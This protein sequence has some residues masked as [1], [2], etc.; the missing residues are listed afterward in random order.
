MATPERRLVLTCEHGGHA[1]PAVW[2]ALFA[3]RREWLASH[4]GW[5]SGALSVARM[6]ARATGSPLIS[7]TTTRLLVDLNRSSHNPAVFSEVTRPLS[8]RQREQLLALHHR[9]H[10]DR[11]RATLAA[12]RRPAIHVAVH[13]FTPIWHG[14]PRSVGIGL[15]YDPR[16]PAERAFAI[17]WQHL[18]ARRLPGLEIRRN[19]PYR[20][21]ADGL[22]TALRREFAQS[23]YIG[24]ELELNQR[25][26]ETPAERRVLS[27]ALHETLIETLRRSGAAPAI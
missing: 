20:G 19:A 3:G 12:G 13:S 2:R 6:L 16:R 10:W 14:K 26:I 23:R 18:L 27:I 5:D 24:F 17:E 22:A 25:L 11:V 9:P 1:V 4:R 8:R 21:D 15:L 7:A